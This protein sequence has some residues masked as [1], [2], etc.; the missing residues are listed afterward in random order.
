LPSV[1]DGIKHGVGPCE[2][3]GNGPVNR[4]KGRAR[5]CAVRDGGPASSFMLRNELGVAGDGAGPEGGSAA[6]RWRR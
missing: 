2:D 3:G 4:W 5:R 6:A 1:L